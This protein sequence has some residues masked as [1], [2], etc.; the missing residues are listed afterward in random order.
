MPFDKNQVVNRLS[1]R[2]TR[3][4]FIR[5]E[6]LAARVARKHRS[7][8]EFIGS[9]RL[10]QVDLELEPVAIGPLFGDLREPDLLSGKCGLCDFKRVCSGCRARAY[11]MTN[12]YLAEEPFCTYEPPALQ[13]EEI[14]L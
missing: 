6:R 11:G 3:E 10:Q 8:H 9:V 7:V 1:R 2:V 12:D 4:K 14:T 13:K 5:V